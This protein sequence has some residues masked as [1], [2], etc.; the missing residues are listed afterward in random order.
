MGG[1]AE[2]EKSAE[3][4]GRYGNIFLV[5]IMEKSPEGEIQELLQPQLHTGSTMQ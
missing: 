1:A 2:Q 3:G 5:G 4:G